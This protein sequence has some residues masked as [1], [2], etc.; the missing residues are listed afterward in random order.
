MVPLLWLP[1]AAFA[2]SVP[3]MHLRLH[4]HSSWVCWLW[5]F[6]MAQALLLGTVIPHGHPLCHVLITVT[7]VSHGAHH[8]CTE[9]SNGETK[10]PC[11]KTR[12]E[13]L[14]SFLTLSGGAARWSACV[15]LL[16]I[17]FRFIT[18]LS[19]SWFRLRLG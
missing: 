11:L 14:F 10:R 15:F 18:S 4:C 16:C 1:S 19:L 2:F 13:S 5:L 3:V 7:E 17:D 8:R 6:L 9:P 12:G